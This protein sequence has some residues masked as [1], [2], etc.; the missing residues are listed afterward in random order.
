MAPPGNEGSGSDDDGGDDEDDDGGFRKKG[1]DNPNSVVQYSLTASEDA[2]H[3]Y[4][5]PYL[6]PQPGEGRPHWHSAGTEFGQFWVYVARN[7]VLGYRFL[8]LDH[9]LMRG[10]G[11]A[12][13]KRGAL[14]ETLDRWSSEEDLTGFPCGGKRA[15]TG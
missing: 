1:H 10:L 12:A 5:A 6:A 8:Q 13:S 4:R 15:L 7:S 2:P 14:V 11:L 9:C 3:P